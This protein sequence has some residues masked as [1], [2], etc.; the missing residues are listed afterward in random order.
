MASSNSVKKRC[1]NYLL[2]EC[3]G[4]GAYGEVF[5]AKYKKEKKIVSHFVHECTCNCN[6]SC[7]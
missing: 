5:L 7:S 3:I 4:K 2:Y 6:S 1:G